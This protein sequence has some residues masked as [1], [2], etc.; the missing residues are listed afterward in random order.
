MHRR[1]DVIPGRHANA[2]RLA[3]GPSR[4]LRHVDDVV[5][6]RREGGRVGGRVGTI[7]ERPTAR[8][9]LASDDVRAD[10]AVNHNLLREIVA[11]AN[12]LDDLLHVQKAEVQII[13]RV[14][15]EIEQNNEVRQNISPRLV[16][17]V[18]RIIFVPPPRSVI[19]GEG[20]TRYGAAAEL[21]GGRS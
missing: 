16:L 18:V 19:H 11:Q 13:H 9:P 20:T 17:P 5:P 6:V 15:V 3:I 2:I 12:F 10:Q 4:N 21:T 8:V 1:V 7:P 14:V